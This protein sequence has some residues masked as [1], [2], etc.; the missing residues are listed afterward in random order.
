MKIVIGQTPNAGD[1]RARH[2]EGVF[3]AFAV[4]LLVARK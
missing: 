1:Q 3:A 2:R 4:L